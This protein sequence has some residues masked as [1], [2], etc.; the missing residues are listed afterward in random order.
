VSV[1]SRAMPESD[2]IAPSEAS[3]GAVAPGSAGR[4]AQLRAAR[5]L[6]NDGSVMC[7]SQ[8]SLQRPFRSQSP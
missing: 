1:T 2:Q 6:S 3:G 4:I 5:A 7:L 8:K